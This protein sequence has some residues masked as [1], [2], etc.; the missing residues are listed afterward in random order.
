MKKKVVVCMVTAMVLALAGC[1]QKKDSLENVVYED[2]AVQDNE[3]AAGQP[4]KDTADTDDVAGQSADDGKAEDTGA[5]AAA[6]FSDAAG[7]AQEPA[8]EDAA[9]GTYEDNFAVDTQ[10]AA[11]FGGKIKE[12]VAGKDI[13]KLADLTTFPVYVGLTEEGAVVETREDFIALGAENL[14]TDEMVKSIADADEE[15]L[16]PSMAGFTL[17]SGEDAPSITFGVQDGKLGICGINY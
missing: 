11:A 1:G 2:S 12:A 14:F 16:S 4:D 7:T 3:D 8:Q 15:G 13:E 9:E 6:D 5:A 10:T 17:Y